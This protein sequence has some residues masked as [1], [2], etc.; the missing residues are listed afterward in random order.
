VGLLLRQRIGLLRVFRRDRVQLLPQSEQVVLG[1]AA[2]FTFLIQLLPRVAPYVA[3][4]DLRFLHLLPDELDEPVPSLLGQPR[5]L[6]ADHLAVVLGVETEVRSQHGLLDGGDLGAVERTDH[7]QIGIRGHGMR[8][9][10]E[11]GGGPVVVDH[12]VLH[13]RRVGSSGM[14][15]GELALE[16]IQRPCHVF[17]CLPQQFVLHDRPPCRES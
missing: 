2:F 6:D 9:V 15:L 3:Q 13:E 17:P 12:H 4:G 11:R 10:L 1:Q 7:D 8:Y 16:H 14:D 5:D